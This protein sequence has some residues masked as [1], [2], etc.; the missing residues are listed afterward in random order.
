MRFLFKLLVLAAIGF[1]GMQ[2]LGKH[3]SNPVSQWLAKNPSI[4]V[5]QWAGNKP[6]NP[7]ASRSDD[8]ATPA[9]PTNLQDVKG[10]KKDMTQFYQDA[11]AQKARQM[12]TQEK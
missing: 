11:A 3:P 6:S 7:V 2:W 9:V 10:F 1:F 12:D 8:L 4:P 5:G